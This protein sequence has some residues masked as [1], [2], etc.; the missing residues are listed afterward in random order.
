MP[1]KKNSAGRVIRHGVA[2]V[3]LLMMTVLGGCSAVGPDYVRPAMVLPEQ[4]HNS[5][6]TNVQDEQR[7]A[8]WW[9]LF[10]DPLLNALIEKT[11]VEN[12]DLQQALSRVKTARLQTVRSEASQFPG[13]DADASAG[14]S[15]RRGGESVSSDSETYSAGFD[16]GWEL[17]I[18]GGV[19]R[20]VQA[21]QLEL[22]AQIEDLH[23]I[24][25]TLLAEVAVN[26]FDL[27]TY[28]NRLELA[29]ANVSLQQETWELLDAVVAAGDGDALALAQAR[30]NL[31]N[32]RARIP[33]LE[34]GLEAAMN[35]LAILTGKPAGDLRHHLHAP[36]PLPQPS[37]LVAVGV[38]ADL[39]RQRPDIRRTERELAAQTERIGIAEADLYPRFSLRGS[40][41]LESISL[42]KLFVSPTR[43]W[44]FGPSI[45][46]PIFDAGSIRNTIKIQE[47]LQ[48]QAY[49]RYQQTVL[50]A[51]EETENALFSYAK[52]Q[53]RLEN[54]KHAAAAAQQAADLAVQQYTTGMT[55][56]NNVLDA[57]RSLLSFADQMAESRGAVLTGLVRIYKTMGGGWQTLQTQY[58]VVSTN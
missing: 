50:A 5:A 29:K 28:Q 51:L 58:P 7:L 27:R 32:S 40:I 12:L 2:C 31:E 39:L 33:G 24:K 13:V 26:Y 6:M 52:E 11:T 37:L 41:G 35:R 55:G 57:Q 4:W 19:R 45:S 25:V 10:K 23:D 47:E 46:W 21:S 15:G 16:A 44:S 53:Q 8:G 30:Y 38:P 43:A 22:E 1:H 49:F 9:Q 17:D 36:Q 20:A 42:D 54:L 18:F 3:A 14:K 34:T 48:Q 56:F